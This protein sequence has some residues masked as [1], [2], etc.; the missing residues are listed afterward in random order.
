MVRLLVGTMIKTAM[1]KISSEEF[2]GL[3]NAQETTVQPFRAPS[4]GLILTKVSYKKLTFD[5]T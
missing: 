2:S 1:G 5:L 3:L 4:R